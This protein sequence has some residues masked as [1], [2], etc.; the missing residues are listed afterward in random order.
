MQACIE[1]AQGRTVDGAT[2]HALG[3]PPALW[4][5]AGGA[6]GPDYWLRVWALRGLLWNWDDTA[7]ATVR[8]ALHDPSWRVREMAARVA[9]KH[10]VDAALED[11]AALREDPVTRVRSAGE[12][13]VRRMTAPMART[14]S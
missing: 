14:T 1:I 9:A 10:L 6:P 7:V 11:L 2:L 13:A 4:A 5:V 3:G 8:H 12:R